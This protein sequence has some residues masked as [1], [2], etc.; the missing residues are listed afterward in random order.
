[1]PIPDFHT[2]DFSQI[3]AIEL[4]AIQGLDARTAA[5]FTPAPEAVAFD[6]AVEPGDVVCAE[7][8]RPGVASRCTTPEATVLGVAT[9]AGLVA[10][11]GRVEVKASAANG[12]IQPGDLLV[13]SAEPGVAVRAQAGEAVRAVCV[14]T[15]AFDGRDGRGT[16][17]CLVKTGEAGFASIAVEAARLRTDRDAMATEVSALRAENEAVKA[18]LGRIEAAMGAL[19]ERGPSGR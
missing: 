4:A 17:S 3:T 14:A 18:R 16:V 9:A 13:P 8:A 10:S 5:I 6:D 11:G 1:V 12:A 7:P 19:T 15:G 2:V